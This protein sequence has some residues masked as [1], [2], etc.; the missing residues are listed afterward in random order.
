VD[1][2]AGLQKARWVFSFQ[3]LKQFA[4][5]RS[6]RPSAS[7]I[8]ESQPDRRSPAPR[9]PASGPSPPAPRQARARPAA[10]SV[11]APSAAGADSSPPWP[12]RPRA[13]PCLHPRSSP[14]TPSHRPPHRFESSWFPGGRRGPGITRDGL[15]ENTRIATGGQGATC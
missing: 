14:G 9:S 8:P 7:R 3:R 10:R 2:A 13:R 6:D 1:V 5:H 4:Q 12:R 11:P 15:E